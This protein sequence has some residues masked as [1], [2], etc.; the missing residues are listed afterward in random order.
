ML[1]SG[2]HRLALWLLQR[3]R[4]ELDVGAVDRGGVGPCTVAARHGWW[5]VLDKLVGLAA[6]PT[7]VGTGTGFVVRQL[8]NKHYVT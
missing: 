8:S 7:Q 1:S 6:D 5:D 2:R 3:C 4:Q